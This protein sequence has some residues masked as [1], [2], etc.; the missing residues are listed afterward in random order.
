MSSSTEF[1]CR[2]R[3]LPSS[4]LSSPLPTSSLVTPVS[5]KSLADHCSPG[6]K[7]RYHRSPSRS[8]ESSKRS[9]VA[10][11]EEAEDTLIADGNT[12]AGSADSESQIG[13][14]CADIAEADSATE[15]EPDDDW[16]GFLDF[17]NK[18]Q[19]IVESSHQKMRQL[20]KN[21]ENMRSNYIEGVR[22]HER[23]RI[24]GVGIAVKEQTEGHT[25]V[26]ANDAEE[27]IHDIEGM[28]PKKAKGKT[29]RARGAKQ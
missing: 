19:R 16:P 18:T 20:S 15:A 8:A 12:P 25:Q 28:T 11:P 27:E 17:L 10:E 5:L 21:F 4:P 26:Q 2:K 3:S 7:K 6:N 23:D 13:E 1:K 14:N 29:K 24:P 9:R 22:Q